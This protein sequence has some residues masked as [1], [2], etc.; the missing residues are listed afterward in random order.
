MYNLFMLHLR[1][2]LAISTILSRLKF[3]RI[4]AL[5]GARQTG[6]SVLARDLLQSRL[7]KSHYITFDQG[8]H[9]NAARTH[10]ETFLS[11][12]EKSQPLILDE[13]QK[14]PEI[15]DALKMRVDNHPSPGQFL[16]LGSTEFSHLTRIRES[17]TGRMGRVRIL[18]MT[19]AETLK[20]KARSDW[21]RADLMSYLKNG[22]MPGILN[23]RDQN[24]R[25]LVIQD[26]IDLTCERDLFQIKKYSLESG[27][28][29]S[30]LELT[31]TLEEPSQAAIASALRIHTRKVS[32]YLAALQALFVI[33]R[34]DPHPTGTGKSIFLP[35]DCA[36]AGTLG[37]GLTRQL[38]IWLLNERMALSEYSHKQRSRFFYYRS[39]S[40][41]W[42]HLIERNGSHERA[43]ELQLS[44]TP[45]K[46]D[47][48]LIKAF[49]AKNPRS[50][51]A[52]YA[53]VM[54]PVKI[55]S[56]AFLPWEEVA[57]G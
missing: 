15:F 31:A 12:H 3:F 52:V 26:W 57:A 8:T 24:S 45:K 7:K 39:L 42:I 20:M 27:I 13:V 5:Q 6:K 25:E 51:G 37:A 30:I 50:R 28:A 35:L 34:L 54:A 17:L 14:A 47:S 53:P 11:S 4:V 43:F 55:D 19:L 2:R 18:P 33:H 46:I 1:T 40:R 23:I 48:A 16:L 32:Q 10:P 38:H 36:I 49:L 29:R 44:E 56:T 22:G 9:A 41:R 21:K